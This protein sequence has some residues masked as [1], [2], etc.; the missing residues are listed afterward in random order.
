[1]ELTDH[2]LQNGFQSS[3]EKLSELWGDEQIYD[4]TP[5]GAKLVLIYSTLENRHRKE[6]VP[7]GRSIY[8]WDRTNKSRL[9]L[10]KLTPEN[11]IDYA[12]DITPEGLLHF[13]GETF[14]T[15]NE[16]LSFLTLKTHIVHQR[17]KIE[18][19]TPLSAIIKQKFES[20]YSLYC[21]PEYPPLLLHIAL[22]NEDYATAAKILEHPLF[23]SPNT[24]ESNFRLDHLLETAT[25]NAIL[26][27]HISFLDFLIDK[28]ETLKTRT[29]PFLQAIERN[30]QIAAKHLLAKYPKT[31][32][33]KL[34]E[35]GVHV[36]VGAKGGNP[37]V[38]Q[39]LLE[40]IPSEI[41]E[42]PNLDDPQFLAL[43]FGK[44]GQEGF[45]QLVKRLN[46]QVPWEPLMLELMKNPCDPK[47]YLPLYIKA[48]HGLKE[49]SLELKGKIISQSGDQDIQDLLAEFFPDEEPSSLLAFSLNESVP[50]EPRLIALFE[51][52]AIPSKDNFET[53]LKLPMDESIR[54][55][56]FKTL[57]SGIKDLSHAKQNLSIASAFGEEAIKSV[58]EVFPSLAQD[59]EFLQLLMGDIWKGAIAAKDRLLSEMLTTGRPRTVVAD[60]ALQKDLSQD[61]FSG[62]MEEEYLA[63]VLGQQITTNL[64]VEVFLPRGQL[65]KIE[66]FLMEKK[67][68]IYEFWFKSIFS[69]YT[70]FEGPEWEGIAARTLYLLE[71]TKRNEL[72]RNG[73]Y[74]SHLQL[75]S[76]WLKQCPWPTTAAV[77]DWFNAALQAGNPDSIAVF[78][79]QKLL[80][81]LNE[82]GESFLQIAVKVNA[83]EFSKI[84]LSHGLDKDHLDKEEY[85]AYKEALN[86]Q[87]I[88]L[89]YLLKGNEAFREMVDKLVLMEPEEV[90][91]W[92]FKALLNGSSSDLLQLTSMLKTA[93]KNLLECCDKVESV[94]RTCATLIVRFPSPSAQQE[95][96]IGYGETYP[97][98]EAQQKN[99]GEICEKHYQAFFKEY[100]QKDHV[101]LE[102]LVKFS[103]T[104]QQKKSYNIWRMGSEMALVTHFHGRYFFFW[105]LAQKVYKALL[106]DPS[107]YEGE[108]KQNDVGYEVLYKIDQE[109]ILSLSTLQ[110]RKPMDR[111]VFK[112]NMLHTSATVITQL[113]P[114]LNSLLAEI[115]NF[116]V[117][118]DEKCPP[119]ELK[120]KIALLF[121]LGC[122]LTPTARGSSQYMLMLHR[123]LYNIHGFHPSPWSMRYVQPDCVAIMLPF[124]LFFD[125][126]YDQLF[127]Y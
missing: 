62:F 5:L 97:S 8:F 77:F 65:A 29:Y 40:L 59:P 96:H 85:T 7:P 26:D 104:Q 113:M 66:A 114:H 91:S 49:L 98:Y 115:K 109:T 21:P 110:I 54:I 119:A 75:A 4:L 52:G 11:V 111:G 41:S 38:L 108:L 94:I 76:L 2:S 24:Q 17:T 14:K 95:M 80:F 47:S 46:V 35:E 116:V 48:G 12:L 100:C 69:G 117:P 45:G 107:R 118:R 63:P 127:E 105:Q 92:L 37:E 42:L 101:V 89:C 50:N 99:W 68:N 19:D 86:N 20:H 27:N 31:L 125:E 16:F 25:G 56:L 72:I 53:L 13:E 44:F 103:K 112:A 81:Q 30:N 71:E 39:W 90:E 58:F 84:L 3:W 55:R 10:Q 61:P 88:T 36:G 23:V 121:W 102:L 78:A 106:K 28:Y 126:Y 123:L 15:P 82:K 34:F 74:Y 83:I 33:P 9:N 70:G 124:S 93:S 79:E 87:R 67:E 6:I 22:S 73:F 64:L 122:H 43:L 32:Y 51:A 60:P 18:P 120:K 1:M 57:L